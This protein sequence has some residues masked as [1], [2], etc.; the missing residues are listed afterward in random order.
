[1][2]RYASVVLYRTLGPTLPKG[3]DAAWDRAAGYVNRTVPRRSMYLRRAEEVLAL[4][5]DYKDLSDAN[6]KGSNLSGANLE[7]ADL[8]RMDDRRRTDYRS[9]VGATPADPPL[10]PPGGEAP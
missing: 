9:E 8:R 6:L 4:E 2:A 1:M 5:K 10:Q 3:L 7:G